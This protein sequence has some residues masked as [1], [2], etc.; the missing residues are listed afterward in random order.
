MFSLLFAQKV[1]TKLQ[2]LHGNVMLVRIFPS[3]ASVCFALLTI[4]RM[5]MLLAKAD[6]GESLAKVKSMCVCVC[7]CMLLEKSLSS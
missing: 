5:P 2:N 1:S 4:M 6:D 7:D 3:P